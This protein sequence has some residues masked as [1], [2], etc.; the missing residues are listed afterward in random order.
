M[1]EI[2]VPYLKCNRCKHRWIPRNPKTPKVCPGCNSPYW[3]K[4]YVRSDKI[5]EME[6]K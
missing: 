6:G 5:K 1:S 4:P 3:D 2:T